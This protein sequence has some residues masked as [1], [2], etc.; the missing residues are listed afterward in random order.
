MADATGISLPT[1]WRLEHNELSNPPLRYLTNCALVLG[2][3]L[4]AVIEDE[5]RNWFIFD[6]RRPAPSRPRERPAGQ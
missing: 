6:E 2:V 5:W 4:E 1:Y 3:G